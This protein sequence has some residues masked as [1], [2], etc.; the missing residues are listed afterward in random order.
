[1][2]KSAVLAVDPGKTTG[3]AFWRGDSDT[4]IVG[5]TEG[6]YN[7]YD[8]LWQHMSEHLEGPMAWVCESYTITE[9]TA[10]LSAQYDALYIIGYMDGVADNGG[11]PFTLQ[12]PKKAKDFITDHVLME[13]NWWVSGKKYDHAMDA[14]RHLGLYMVDSKH[15]FASR[16]L[17]AALSA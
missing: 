2:S 10:K 4:P 13:L 1:M 16:V 11:L 12:A 9:A 14:C 3:W 7:F 17:E 15:P 5:Q 6:R 8:L